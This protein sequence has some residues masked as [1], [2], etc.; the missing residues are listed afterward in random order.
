M[1]PSNSRVTARNRAEP[2]TEVLS[3]VAATCPICLLLNRSVELI[4][5]IDSEQSQNAVAIV[6][7]GEPL[8]AVDRVNQDL[9][10]LRPTVGRSHI[11]AI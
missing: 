4:E 10:C 8:P 5:A 2:D 9:G 1:Y 6:R 3:A 7:G 11:E